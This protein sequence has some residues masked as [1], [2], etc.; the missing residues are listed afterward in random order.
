MGKKILNNSKIIKNTIELR[1]FFHSFMRNES[2]GG[3]LLLVCAI[4]AILFVNVIDAHGWH[5]FW[6]TK[7]GIS[8]GSFN[9]EMTLEQWINDGLMAIFFFVVGLEIKR[10]MMV[11]ELSSF[12]HAALPIFAAIGGMIVPAVLYSIFNYDNPDTVSGWGIPMATDIAFALG[13]LSLVGS[14]APLSLKIFLTA[15]AIV[16]DLGAIIVLAIFYPTHALH[17]DM[18]FIAAIIVI[19]LLVLNRNRVRHALLYIIPGIFLWY[20][21]FMSG[22]HATIAGVILALTIPSKTNINEVR[23]TVSIKYWIQKFIN[24]SNSEIE[25]LANPAQQHIIHQIS[26]NVRKINPMM[27]RFEAALHPWTTFFVMPIFAL[28]NSGVEFTGDLFSFPLPTVGIGIF[29][30]LLLGKPIGIFLFSFISV[31]LKIADLPEGTR[32]S[33]IFAL[34]IL[35]GI[36]FTMSIFI[37]GLAFENAYDINIGKAAILLTSTLAAIIGLGA[38]LLTNRKN[39]IS[40]K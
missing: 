14:R 36:G 9:L 28:A 7:A 37:D 20:F 5:E 11:G 29:F 23:F 32:W 27:H 25:V 35:A 18:L 34:G 1:H 40:N 10:E 19:F 22:I 16:D 13:I 33:Q 17:F 30:G 24:V 12:K 3:I 31:K 15:L 39:E 2:I 8:I 6:R 26:E 21:I 38:V 4:I